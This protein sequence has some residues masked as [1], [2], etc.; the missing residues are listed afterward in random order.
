MRE[1][2]GS[3]LILS[4]LR[5]Q[6]SQLRRKRFQFSFHA[7]Q[8]VEHGKTFFKNTAPGE[9]QAVLRQVADGGIAG[10]IEGAVVERFQV[11]HDLQQG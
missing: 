8:I 6:L 7:A 11:R 3:R 2:R 1:A 9:S 4:A 5:V 10:A